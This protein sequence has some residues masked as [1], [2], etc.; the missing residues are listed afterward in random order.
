MTWTPASGQEIT[1]ARLATL[2]TVDA[3]ATSNQSVN[4]STTLVSDTVLT[5]TVAA[6]EN[7]VFEAVIFYT[8][9]STADFKYGF[10]IPTSA[11]LNWS[12]T[13]LSPSDVFE[14]VT[15]AGLTTSDQTNVAGGGG[16]THPANART[17]RIAGTLRTDSNAGSLTFRFAQNSAVA[18]NATRHA[19]SSMSVRQVT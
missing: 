5:F 9:G 14:Q 19:G 10:A 7:Y 17:I 12:A 2:V 6:N 18:E 16:T 13:K 3:L 1:S 15:A 8:A 11:S 4:N